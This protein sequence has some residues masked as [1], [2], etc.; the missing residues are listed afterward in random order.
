MYQVISLGNKLLHQVINKNRTSLVV[1]CCLQ[2]CISCTIMNIM[3]LILGLILMVTGV[4]F[5]VLHAKTSPY[6]N[7]LYEAIS[8]CFH[9]N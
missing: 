1:C 2:T 5:I 8:Y 6:Y 7:V 4:T 3:G 9:G